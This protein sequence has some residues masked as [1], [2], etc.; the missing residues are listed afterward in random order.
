MT[1][2]TDDHS[3]MIIR[4]DYAISEYSPLLLSIKA[5]SYPKGCQWWGVGL[6][7]DIH[8]ATTAVSV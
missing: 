7:P 4:A 3:K 8:L 5:L 1:Q 6:R 2:T